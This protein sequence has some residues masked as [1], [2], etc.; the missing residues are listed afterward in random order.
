MDDEEID[1]ALLY[2]TIGIAWEALDVRPE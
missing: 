1:I 2:P